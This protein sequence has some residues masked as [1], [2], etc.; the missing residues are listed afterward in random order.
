MFTTQTTICCGVAQIEIHSAKSKGDFMHSGIYADAELRAVAIAVARNNVGAMRPE[1]EIAASE[2]ITDAEFDQIKRNP[3]FK[4]Y[5]EVYERDLRENGFSF[6]A[7]SRVLAEDL[8]P[9]AYFLARD[10]NIPPAVRVKMIENLVEWAELKPK[11]D[12]GQLAVGAGFSITIN[13][14]DQEQK[15]PK[16]RE[17]VIEHS[18]IDKIE[19][20]P[21]EIEEIEPKIDQKTPKLSLKT[22]FDEGEDYEY[23]GDDIL[24]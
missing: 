1:H 5:L 23:A 21:I 20:K 10:A 19:E 22:L 18:E 4:Q 17:I 13:L 12:Q 8:L 24:A 9:D 7:K 3:Q 14:P 15:T 11:K 6:S 16:E 2:G